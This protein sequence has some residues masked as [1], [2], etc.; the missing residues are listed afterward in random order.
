LNARERESDRER[1]RE[2]I[3]EIF[4]LNRRDEK[5]ESVPV[6]FNKKETKLCLNFTT[7]P[8]AFYVT[9]KVTFSFTFCYVKERRI[10][11]LQI[12]AENKLPSTVTKKIK[13]ESGLVKLKF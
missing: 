12:T 6:F 13:F 5:R 10:S 11:D 8:F 1:V 3:L 2:M 4:S 7:F 9:K